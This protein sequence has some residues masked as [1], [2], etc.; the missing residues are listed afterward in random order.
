[1]RSAKLAQPF[2]ALAAA[3]LF[4]ACARAPARGRVEFTPLPD[5]EVAHAINPHAHQGKPLCQRCHVAGEERPSV[6]PIA[7]CS[8]CH[9]AARMRHPKGV[10]QKGGA[11]PLPLLEGDRIACHTC[12][13]PH[14]VKKNPHGLR[15]EQ[16]ALCLRCH[17]RH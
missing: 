8:Q 2:A 11:G 1:M 7:L 12:H 5:V 17:V 14:D 3:A 16:T 10:E 4:A 6:D 15:D 13:D 9:D